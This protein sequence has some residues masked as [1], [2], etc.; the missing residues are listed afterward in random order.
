VSGT[1]EA[2][3]AVKAECEGE[4]VRARMVP[5]DYAS[6]SAQVEALREEIHSVLAEVTP[7][8]VE[9]PMISALTGE[10]LE[11]PEL[12]AGYWYRSLRE[13]VEFDRAVRTLAGTGHHSFVECSPHP[14]LG[15]ALTDTLAD[16]DGAGSATTTGT[17][18]RDDGGARRLLT[19]LAEAHVRGTG[20]DWA[21][22]LGEGHRIALPT[23]AFQ[24]RRYWPKPAAPGTPEQ[25]D[26]DRAGSAAE[27]EFWAAVEEGRLDELADTLDVDGRRLRE[28]LP[29]LASWRRRERG[30][31]AVADWRYRV[32]W[33]PVTEPAAAV[34]GGTWLLLAGPGE[35]DLTEACG[36]ALRSAGARVETLELPAD[37]LDRAGLA[38]RV[39]AALPDGTRPAGILSL[40]ALDEQP[41]TGHPV[42]TAGVA[43]TLTLIQAA[44]DLEITAPLWVATRGAVATAPGEDPVRAVQTQTWGLGQVAGLEHPDR[45]GGLID[46][47]PRWDGRTPARLS[48]VL[49]GLAEDQVALRDSGILARRLVRAPRPA[50]GRTPWTPRGSALIT[51]GTGGIGGCVARWMA[52]RGTPRVVLTSRSGPAAAGVPGLVTELVAAGTGV[53][54][55]ACDVARREDVAGL[56]DHLAAGGPPLTSVVHSAGISRAGAVA[57]TTVAELAELAE[58]KVAGA[59]WLDELTDGLELDAFVMFSSGAATWGSGLLGGYA[60]ANAH[61]DGLAENRRA[62]GLA[63]TSLAWGLWGGVGMGVGDA[64][65]ALRRYG[66]R[67]MDPDRGIQAFAQAMDDQDVA[68]TV[69]D[70]EWEQFA[71]TFTLRRRSPLIESL[72]EVADALR[73][74]VEDTAPGS[75]TE[76]GRRLAEL[77]PAD[78]DRMLVDLVRGEAAAVLGHQGIDAIEP[79]RAFKELGFD[80]VTAVE[81]RNRVGT[82]TGLRLPATLVFDYPSASALAG[83]LRGELL[84]ERGDTGTAVV[85]PR[86]AARDDDPI[87]VV[88][89]GCRYPGGVVSPEQLWDVLA[90]GTDATSDFPTDRGWDLD[91]YGQHGGYVQDAAEFDPG[92]FGISPREAVAMDPQQRLLLEVSWE[93]LER[94]GID[95]TSLRGTPTGVFAGSWLQVYG[96]VVLKDAA[97]TQGYLPTSDG[98]SVISGR[99]SYTLGLEGPA[100]T[101]DTACSASLVAL[102]LAC[103]AL[104]NG[105]CTLA[106]AGGVTVMPST[107]PFGFGANLGLAADGRCKA[108]SASAD[109]MGMG[110]GA[111]ML[112][113]ER[114]SD[115]RRHGH[116]VLAVVAG[117]AVNQDGASNGFTA[118]NGPSQQRVIRAALAGARL[119]ASDIDAV[120]AHGTGTVLGDPIEAQALIAT[121]GRHRDGDRPVWLG[122]I[123][124]NLGHTQGAAG[125]AGIMKLI[126]A[127]RHQ[128]L[129]RTLYADQPTR[130]VDWSAGRV[131]LLA[132]PV[133]WPASDR[134]RRAGVSGFGISGT[135]AHVIIEEPPPAGP[136]ATEPPAEPV[137]SPALL[138][139]TDVTAWVV[140]GRT[141]DGLAA[142]AGR[143]R[144]FVVARPELAPADV[145]WSLATTRSTF[146]HRAVVAGSDRQELAARLAAVTT[147]QFTTGAVT[148]SVP[149]GGPGR[150]VFV[151]PGQG[152]Q[153]VGMGRELLA[154]SPLFAARLDECSAA[155]APWVDWS[156]RDVLE[157]ADGAPGLRSAEVMQPVL[158][159]VMVSLA[160]LWQAAG[161]RPDAVVGHSQGE[162]AAAHVAGILTLEDA[163]RVVALRSRA[164]TA[165]GVQ[166]GLLSAVL[167]EEQVR[168]LLEP[169][170]ERLSVAAVNGPAATVVSGEPAA[171]TEFERE[172]S[173]RKILRWRIPENDFVAHSR[174]VEPV[175]EVL[176]RELAGIRPVTGQVPLYS[177]V[178][179]GRV[180]GGTLDA[181]YWYD[182]VR[183]TVRF[184]DTVLAL[185]RDGYRGWVEV[186]PQPVLTT[187]VDEVI[188][189]HDELPEPTVTGTLRRDDGGP[190]RLLCSF[191]EAHVRGLPVDWT[192]VLGGGRR[193]E[194]PTYAFQHQHYWPRPGG[195]AAEG[196]GE[197]GLSPTGHQLLGA[198]VELAGEGGL[199]FTGR[200]SVKTHPWLADHTVNGVTILP[201][202]GFVELAL[203]AADRSGAGGVEDLTLEAPLVL[204]PTGAVQLQVAVGA[205]DDTGRRTLEVYSRPGDGSGE[206]PWTRN[207]GGTLSAPG[208]VEPTRDPD[209][210]QWPPAGAEPVDIDGFYD[211]AAAG[212][213][214]LG[215]AFRGLRAVWRRG[216][217]VFAE[218]RLPDEL[219]DDVALF[220]L[221]PALLDAAQQ[222]S[223]LAAQSWEPGETW[224]SFGWSGVA[225][226]ATGARTLRVRWRREPDERISMAASDPTGTPV[227]SADALVMRRMTAEQLPTEG[228][229]LRDT[230]FQIDWAPVPSAAPAAGGPGRW[231][232]L[233]DDTAGLA[234]ELAAAGLDVRAHADVPALV[235]AVADGE[236]LPG[237][238][239]YP[240]PVD[241]GRPAGQRARAVTAEVL[242][243]VQDWLAE[244]RLGPA[245][246]VVVTRG[247]MPALPGEGV[248]DLAGAS[249]WG[250][251]RSAQSEEPGRVVL[252]DLPVDGGTGPLEALPGALDSDEPELA[253]RGERQVLARRLARPADGLAVPAA[254]QPWRLE[255]G[256]DGAALRPYPAAGEPLGAG[257]VR[258]AVRA[259]RLAGTDPARLLG[260]PGPDGH[261]PGDT[262]AGLVLATGPEV[263]GLAPGDRVCGEVAG[264]CGPVAVA[265]AARLVPVPADWTLTE[266]AAAPDRAAGRGTPAS[267]ARVGDVRR[268]VE[269]LRAT[270]RDRTGGPTVLTV[271]ADPAESRVP[272]TVLVTGGTGTLGALVARHL[273][274]TGR[275][276]GLLLTS[277]SGPAASGAPA[278]AGELAGAGAEV[279]ITS[280]DTSDPEQLDRLVGTLPSRRALTGVVHAAGVLDDGVIPAL[281]PGRVETVM[282]AKSDSAWHLHRLT[283]CRDLDMFVLFSSFAATAGAPGQGNYAA[284]NAFLDG[285]AVQRRAAGLP[286]VSLSW[287]LWAEAS[288]MTGGLSDAELA[289][290]SRAGIGSL[291]NQVGLALLDQALHRHQAMLVPAPLNL[292]ALRGA[293]RSGVALPAFLRG[294]APAPRVA[295]DS[296]P[297]NAAPALRERL[298]GA[299]EPERRRLLVDVVR[300]E[301]AGVLGH[302]VADA[303]EIDVTFLEQ[304]LNSLTAVELRN[305]LN[306]VTGLRMT[307]AVAFDHP[308]PDE[309]AGHLLDRLVATGGLGGSPDGSGGADRAGAAPVDPRRYVAAEPEEGAGETVPAEPGGLSALYA[310]AVGTGRAGEVMRLVTGL[311]GFRRSFTDASELQQIPQIVPVAR[312]SAGPRLVCLPSFAGSSD[313]QEFARF[314]GGF[315]GI[316]DVS[317][318]PTPGFAA[319]EPLAA[320]TEALVAVHSES[321]RKSVGDAPFVLAGYSS[322][323]LV[324]HVLAARLSALGIAPTGI[325]LIDTFTPEVAGVPEEI[326]SILP[327]AVLSNNEQQGNVGGDDWLTALAHYYSM[328]WRDLPRI[329]IPTLLVRASDNGDDA[330]ISEPWEFSRSVTEAYVPGDHFSM[331]GNHADT[332]AR[333]V[334]EWLAELQDGV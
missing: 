207:A 94:A 156:V 106:L 232:V 298:A 19:S 276:R 91:G 16:T 35:P 186:S 70:V 268:A 2:L 24:H 96:T 328:D 316:R 262:V 296:A 222:A 238:V 231:V 178:R 251:V 117:S 216:E 264:G 334:E 203:A 116:E 306:L 119:E 295:R 302:G 327:A 170:G 281:T 37:G 28:L 254:G 48:A 163:A 208:A 80:S 101:V 127:M 311:A 331:M 61:L 193:V 297:G 241:D 266:A 246:L 87:V 120:E 271:N 220:G 310:R 88:G 17:L 93:A 97:A 7:R 103:Q 68:L 209:F 282:R 36:Q 265:D 326:L 190:A 224:L 32:E 74:A 18:R 294:L 99:V 38:E 324:A 49:A 77:E 20:V 83:Q 111:G 272:G 240:V 218:T 179:A 60:A 90:S 4:G 239:L 46:L 146:G 8:E 6:H 174:L 78:Q 139:G 72:P 131:R 267:P 290:F 110:E 107:G 215:P 314:A 133:G 59:N 33:A 191:G 172:L 221:H 150:V 15:G 118:P 171:L 309:L 235:A 223:V 253:V 301:T 167:P 54:V 124:S 115:A 187:S 185:A 142:Q 11:G 25:A 57:D 329:D 140:S 275:A 270:D 92:F 108:F 53:E 229:E 143:L 284:A 256:P 85:A 158:W 177:T 211:V 89:M 213:Y 5:V 154:C 303:V 128:T 330:P 39:A 145:A 73:G 204:Q 98:G 126:L 26:A 247:S 121:Y 168:E 3:E 152:A 63:A 14:V 299:G 263:E 195:A 261:A 21:A 41:G 71:P 182:N 136:P 86:G 277:R 214:G 58:A 129:P 248:T 137:E 162:I 69:S 260:G 56:L 292:P 234:G 67:V 280:C 181:G 104:R 320:T 245:R 325:V 123:K 189:Q 180:D 255:T 283:R 291:S 200:L 50:G 175:R 273:A 55:H 45:W 141:E 47:P 40:L 317:V 319:G 144:E 52:G 315:R 135:N 157:G 307:G 225:L 321:I 132:E 219:G 10:M 43:A 64:G 29:A 250:L 285:L 23:Y 279:R 257:Q 318:V 169:W 288:R 149:T 155:L 237:T 228:A 233:G 194:L 197:L 333:A 164:L 147:A 112:V 227:V 153:W 62:R 114:L 22:V 176:A 159:A 84:G 312:G 192:A 183:R 212:G 75:S 196:A 252:L 66:L 206:L 122:S 286:A 160:E 102:H 95:P 198:G 269:L 173:R 1:P 244:D 13:T 27:T 259:A 226:H 81:L 109:G 30:D 304:G 79:D 105:E 148:G 217:D 165:L 151:F 323:G 9:I 44:G 134:V 125:V 113:V 332:T 287:G 199:L 230:L 242:G 289:K 12:D 201:G 76:L 322:G 300:G 31:S 188:E 278:L 100:V 138:A 202:S 130:E 205:P 51:G 305:R 249:V 308:T 161:I 34:L 236:V 293:A 210:A 274:D 258:V 65:D 42:V 166:G 82:A 243:L 184:A 313:A